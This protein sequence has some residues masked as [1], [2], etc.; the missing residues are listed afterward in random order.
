MGAQAV[1]PA[2]EVDEA[3]AMSHADRLAMHGALL[4]VW[5]SRSGTLPP[6]WLTPHFARVVDLVRA[7]LRP[8]TSRDSLAMS[9][10]REHF[11]VTGIA[12][13]PD[14]PALLTTDATEVAYALRWLELGS[15]ERSA[16]GTRR[17]WSEILDRA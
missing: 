8:L 6:R 16:N 4:D 12:V 15:S 14:S 13:A 11:H 1:V 2:I 17:T 5:L 3:S 10:A 9:Y 7:H